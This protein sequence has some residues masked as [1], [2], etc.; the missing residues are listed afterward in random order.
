MNKLPSLGER[1]ASIAS[2]SILHLVLGL[3]IIIS[4]A[5][6]FVIH[7]RK[8]THRLPEFPGEGWD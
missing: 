7:S 2:F 8:S 4:F 6:T 5:I 1:D 3:L